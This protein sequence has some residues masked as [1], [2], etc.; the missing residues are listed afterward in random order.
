LCRI[1][2]KESSRSNRVDLQAVENKEEKTG[3]P[4]S[5]RR[6]PASG[7]N[8][9]FSSAYVSMRCGRPVEIG[10]FQWKSEKIDSYKIDYRFNA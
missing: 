3:D 6:F 8:L 5:P 1:V 4:L 9:L 7:R 10:G 2:A